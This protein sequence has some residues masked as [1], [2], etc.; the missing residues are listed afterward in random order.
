MCSHY[1]KGQYKL[2]PVAADRFDRTT[3]ESFHALGD[4]LFGCG[5]LVDERIATIV[6]S[7]EKAFGC[8]T[9]EITVD[10]LSIDVEFAR[11]V[12]WVFVRL[13]GHK[14]GCTE[15]LRLGATGEKLS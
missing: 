6:I 15:D 3:L 1:T 4:L 7:R 9:T 5:L 8:F 10:T 13:C 2:L 11:Y 14:I 12:D